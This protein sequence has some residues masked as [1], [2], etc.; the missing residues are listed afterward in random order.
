MNKFY[1]LVILNLLIYV[2][3]LDNIYVSTMAIF[4]TIG[5]FIYALE[6]SKK[7][8]N[9]IIALELISHPV[10]SDI[11]NSISIEE[12]IQQKSILKVGKNLIDFYDNN[13]S[14]ILDLDSYRELEGIFKELVFN[15][16][17][18]NYHKEYKELLN[19]QLEIL[20]LEIKNKEIKINGKNKR[21]IK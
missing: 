1:F 20:V 14:M 17:D 3:V 8:K 9:K 5:F 2:N 7:E 19:A 16:K 4:I 6:D 13:F 21:N 12:L 11:V 10:T 18:T 15:Y